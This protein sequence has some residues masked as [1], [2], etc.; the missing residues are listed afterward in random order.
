MIIDVSLAKKGAL[1]LSPNMH[2]LTAVEISAVADQIRP[3]FLAAAKQMK[4]DNDLQQALVDIYIPL[5]ACLAE[6]SGERN[7]PPVIGVNGAQGSG[8]STLCKLLQIVL[9]EGFARHV[10]TL[11]IDDIYLTRTERETLAKEVHPL[12]A[13]RGVPGTHDVTLGKDLLTDLRRIG[14]GQ[15]IALPVF[16]KAIDDRCPNEDFR[17]VKGP[18]DLIL[19]EG[20]CVGAKPQ[21]EEALSSAVN[22]LESL[23]D[24]DGI[25]RSYVNKQLQNDYKKLFDEIDFLIMLKIP[26]MTSVLEWR[27]KQERKLSQ[28]AGRSGYRIMDTTE[29]QR[30]IMHYERL[31]RAMLAEMPDR[32]DLVF[33]LNH[34]HQID[35][36]QINHRTLKTGS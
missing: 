20:W 32:A 33:E 23:E 35:G 6:L 15:S 17:Q 8:K 25:W 13:T 1:M 30:F 3:S 2:K 14:P 29:L 4:I 31:T 11:S 26:G 16:N 34:S 22:S 19:F 28:T 21:R 7:S 18:V 10:V 9:E 12:L 24:P 27:S 36:V 5:A